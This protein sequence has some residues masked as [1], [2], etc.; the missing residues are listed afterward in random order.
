MGLFG[1][2]LGLALLVWLALKNPLPVAAPISIF[3]PT[4][5]STAR[6]SLIRPSMDGPLDR[7]RLVDQP[8]VLK[9][10]S[11]AQSVTTKAKR[12]LSPEHQRM[13]REI[14]K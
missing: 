4:S 6:M 7:N 11:S 10:A 8:R 9:V 2:L 3:A 12:R 14:P 1:I 5:I 13:T